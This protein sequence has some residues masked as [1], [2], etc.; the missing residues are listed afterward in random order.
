M[1]GP[2][3]DFTIYNDALTTASILIKGNTNNFLINTTTDAGFRLD[4]NGTARIQG[5]LNVSTGGVTL[6]GAQTIQTSTGNLTL[7]TAAGNGNILL[8]PHGSGNVGI[9]TSSPTQ[10]LHVSGSGST[11]SSLVEATSNGFRAIA[12]YTANTSGGTPTSL[13]LGTYADGG[14]SQQIIATGELK[15]RSGTSQPLI[16]STNGNTERMRI[17]SAGNVLIN[18]TTDAGFRLD[19]NG[20]ARVSQ[21][22]FL[23]SAS[24]NVNIGTLTDLGYKLGVQGS[25]GIGGSLL[26]DSNVRSFGQIVS[27]GVAKGNSGTA[28]TFDWNQGNVQ[29][30]T[31]TGN[32]T[33]TLSNPLQG[34]SYQI[35]ITQDATGSRTITWPTI[36]WADKTV[37]TLTGTANSVDVVTLTYDGAKY[38]GVISKNHGTP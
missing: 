30:V 2:T 29:R 22:V 15:L 38:L 7:A 1:F 12:N 33:F 28:V 34:A 4:V 11:V 24:G 35:I 21:G 8:S 5:N 31:M 10:K 17:T 32:A 23:S 20:T 37:P 3:S 9:G 16:F 14:D 6:T 27:N 26:A 36:H 25:V 19:V 13:Q 18:T